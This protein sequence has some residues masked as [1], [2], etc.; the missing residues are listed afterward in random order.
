M[1]IRHMGSSAVRGTFGLVSALLLAVSATP[2]AFGQSPPSP[3]PT[4]PVLTAPA[5]A[6]LPAPTGSSKGVGL[7]GDWWGARSFLADRGLTLDLRYSSSYQ[8]LASGTGRKLSEYEYGGKA[9]AFVNLDFGKMGLWKGGGFRSHMEYKHGDAPSNLGGALFSVNTA[10]LWPIDASE[11][12]VAT[13]LYFTQKVGDRIDIAL[14]KVNPVDLLAADPFF[15]GWGI[16]RFMNLIFVAPPSGLVPPVFM[17]V[18]AA[19]KAKPVSW[20]I[21]VFDPD[22]RTNDY[23]PGDLFTNGLNVSVTGAHAAT[24]AGRK[25]SYA[26][27]ANYSTAEGVD[28]SALP[29]NIKTTTK[30]GSYNVAFQFTHNLRES[31]KNPDAA[32]RFYFKG[33]IADGNPNYVKASVIAGI[34]GRALLFGRPQDSFGL[35]AFYYNL[36]DELQDSAFPSVDFQNESAVEAYYNCAATPWLYIGA[37]VQYVNPARGGNELALVAALRTQIRF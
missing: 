18:V 30:K 24:L 1:R 9:D 27:T 23:F 25:T 21:M 13:S 33:A 8:G 19:I 2:S 22:D 20:T 7:T 5:S 10:Q 6:P 3:P 17:G 15:G 26:V 36:S 34:G 16:D 32:W 28:F 35:G 4:P 29:P 37:D 12:V 31:T 14:G 11:E